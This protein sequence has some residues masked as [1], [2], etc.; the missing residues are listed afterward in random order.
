VLILAVNATIRADN[1]S[2]LPYYEKMGFT[3]YKIVEAAPLKNGTPVDRI[4]KK[5]SFAKE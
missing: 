5:Y 1:H 3:T 4:C 2:G